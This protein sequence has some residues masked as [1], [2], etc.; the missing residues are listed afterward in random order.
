MKTVPLRGTL[1]GEP[2]QAVA[3]TATYRSGG[4]YLETWG[5]EGRQIY[6]LSRFQDCHEGKPS[7]G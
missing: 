6:E 5:E 1:L 4:Q 2:M 3:V 7:L